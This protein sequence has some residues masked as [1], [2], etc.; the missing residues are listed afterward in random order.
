[1]KTV[2][3]LLAAAIAAFTVAAA[4]AAPPASIANTTWTLKVDGGADEVLHIDTQR[5]SGAPGNLFCRE[6][7]GNLAGVALVYG[8]YCPNDGRI[9]LL[10][11]NVTTG[12]VMRSFMGNVT[13]EVA[14][15]PLRM[16]GTTSIDYAGLGDLGEVS[17][18]AQRQ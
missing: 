11:T 17:F 15:Q 4:H 2:S 18:R 16:R 5:G 10:H 8:W 1:M 14:G 12:V 7:R 13:E 9:H 3:K 6:V